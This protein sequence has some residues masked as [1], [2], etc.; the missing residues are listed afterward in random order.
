MSYQAIVFL[1]GAVLAALVLWLFR[2]NKKNLS[3]VLKILTVIFCAIGFVRFFLSD[4]ILF[5]INGGWYESGYYE[6]PDFLHVILRWGYFTNYSV[7]PVAV[8][9]GGR[10]FKNV[11]GY[12]SLPFTVISTV[13]FDDYMTYF[14]D[15]KG[16]GYHVDP[17]FRCVF[18][19]AELVLAFAI[20]I[21][22]HISEK[23]VFNVKRG[24]EWVRYLIGL[25]GVILV[26][27][28]AYAP[29]TFWGTNQKEPEWFEPYHLIWI[30]ISVLALIVLYY[31][32]RFRTYEERYMLCFF[33]IVVL[34][35][36]YNS[37]YLKGLTLSR[38]PFD[39]CNLATYLY[40]IAFLLK[41]TKMF[42]FCFIANTIGT[43]FAIIIPSFG[44]GHTGFWNV[45][46][47][48][49]HTLVLIIPFLLMALRIF[50]RLTRKSIGYFFVGFTIYI[51]FCYI[52][53]IIINGELNGTDKPIVNWFY[54]FNFEVAFEEYFAFLKFIANYHFSFGGGKYIVYP[55]VYVVVY[56]GFASI[57]LLFY[58]IA[59]KFYKIEDEWLELRLS[60]IDL[61]EKITK[62]KSKFTRHYID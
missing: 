51:T 21:I 44:L 7:L 41:S 37:M 30:G 36:H 14:L 18:F 11:A 2:K 9:C 50:P 5:S 28:P 43:L 20:P 49:Q 13:F 32:F 31:V 61:Y 55:L 1:C 45:H 56:A 59:K 47:L 23:H 57:C 17:T 10:F 6:N 33:L 24:K 22:L 12:F 15:P 26:T 16:E 52:L 29:Q 35:F 62:K 27:M 46:F 53:G 42:H 60:A 40:L 39:L 4:A 48:Y 8:F 34:F 38:L 19:V 3:I 54:M 58:F 25:P